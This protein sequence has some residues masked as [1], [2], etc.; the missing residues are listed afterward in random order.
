MT[1]AADLPDPSYEFGQL[2]QRTDRSSQ[3]YIRT[4]NILSHKNTLSVANLM[5]HHQLQTLFRV[6]V[7]TVLYSELSLAHS[8]K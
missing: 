7:K 5:T 1:T 6:G 2:L 4:I 8:K 3:T